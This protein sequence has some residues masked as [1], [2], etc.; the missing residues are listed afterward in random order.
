MRLSRV[1]TVL[2]CLFLLT[3]LVNVP[4]AQAASSME[5]DS[6]PAYSG[7][8]FKVV[9]TLGA[10]PKQAMLKDTCVLGEAKNAFLP[11]TIRIVNM[12]GFY[13]F[14]TTL[15]Q[16]GTYLVS[17]RCAGVFTVLNVEKTLD[18]IDRP[19]PVVT[20]PTPIPTNAM[21][22]E[23]GNTLVEPKVISIRCK[24]NS[25]KYDIT[26]VT[27]PKPQCPTN[28]RLLLPDDPEYNGPIG[29]VTPATPSASPTPTPDLVGTASIP[30]YVWCVQSSTGRSVKSVTP[31]KPSCPKGYTA[32]D[33]YRIP[34]EEVIKL[35]KPKASPS[36]LNIT[37]K[38]C[39]KST[40]TK[41][42]NGIKVS[43]ESVNGVQPKC[44]PGYK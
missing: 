12:R 20:A 28:Y 7:K 17:F 16:R 27:G 25:T 19:T 43:T 15:N 44:P 6:A 42:I 35:G 40:D 1:N 13:S 36:P 2:L 24:S 10:L 29:G 21:T 3:G 18:V 38:I 5:F 23:N 14:I 22:D 11:I 26:N 32:R 41:R 31:Y 33:Y 9:V 34:T 8:P 37:V 30:E 39:Y 4:A